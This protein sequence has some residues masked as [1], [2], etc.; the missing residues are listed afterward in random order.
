MKPFEKIS[1]NGRQICIVDVSNS[2]PAESKAIFKEAEQHIAALPL[3]SCLLL[4]DVTNAAY[5]RD[6]AAA[7]TEYASHN[8][9]YI[10]ASAVI[11]A[12][13][14]RSV[15]LQTVALMTKRE[16]KAFKTRNEALE[17]LW[18]QG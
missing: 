8:T 4:T 10:K 17:W 7:V 18:S 5:E 6:S 1:Y 3:K 9:P 12:D 14:L 2:I 16:I 13:S 11:G 15:M